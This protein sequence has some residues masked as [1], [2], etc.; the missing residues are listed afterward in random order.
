MSEGLGKK[1]AAFTKAD[2]PKDPKKVVPLND[3]TGSPAKKQSSAERAM[4]AARRA[5]D[6]VASSSS[7]TG[8]LSPWCPS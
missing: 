7:S 6:I 8:M 4:E 5:S 3:V 2:A 1:N